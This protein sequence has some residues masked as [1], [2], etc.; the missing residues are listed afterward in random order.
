MFGRYVEERGQK[1]SWNFENALAEYNVLLIARLKT[2][3]G[4][5]P[6]GGGGVLP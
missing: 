6:G 3:Q 5:K 1:Q 2:W 4:R